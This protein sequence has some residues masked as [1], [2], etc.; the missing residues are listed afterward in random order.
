LSFFTAPPPTARS[1]HR[2]NVFTPTG[3]SATFW[4]SQERSASWF[5]LESI[6]ALL[7]SV[8]RCQFSLSLRKTDGTPK[9]TS[10]LNKGPGSSF[11]LRRAAV[12][13]PSATPMSGTLDVRAVAVADNVPCRPD[14]LRRQHQELMPLR[15]I[16]QR[17]KISDAVPPAPCRSTSS[18]TAA[19]RQCGWYKQNRLAPAFPERPGLTC[20]W[21]MPVDQ[22]PGSARPDPRTPAIL[23]MRHGRPPKTANLSELIRFRHIA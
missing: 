2:L 11:F 20:M 9:C 13:S 6:T 15:M 10:R 18:G 4:K 22:R 16:R 17:G 7:V 21:R 8:S 5:P 14:R 3:V 23:V 19:V 12:A 1:S